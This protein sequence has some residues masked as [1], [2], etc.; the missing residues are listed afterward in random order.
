MATETKIDPRADWDWYFSTTNGEL[1]CEPGT[2]ENAIAAGLLEVQPGE[3]FLIAQGAPHAPWP[4]L[5]DT[6]SSLG[7]YID[8][9]N[10]DNSFE[11]GFTDEA[12]LTLATLTSLVDEIN[13]VWT[14]FLALHKPTSNRLDVGPTE[15][16]QHPQATT[17]GEA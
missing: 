14:R 6:A 8:D 13:A 15:E 12:G 7:E 5:F 1:W 3:T 11:D 16:I 2:R 10:E 9:T 4:K 17:E